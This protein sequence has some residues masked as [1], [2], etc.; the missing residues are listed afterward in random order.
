MLPQRYDRCRL[1]GSPDPEIAHVP[2]L[3]PHR[4]RPDHQPEAD[5]A[6]GGGG[7]LDDVL[8]DP[9]ARDRRGAGLPAL[10]LSGLLGLPAAQR[11]A[12]VPLRGL[13][14]RLQ[15]DLGHPVRLPQAG[16]PRLPGGG[17]DLLRRGQ[18]QGRAGAVARPRRP[19]QDRLRPGPQA[20]RGD[21]VGGQGP[22]ARRRRAGMSRSTAV[23]SAATSG[24]RTGR[25][26]AGTG[27]WRRTGAA[28]A[29]SSW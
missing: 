2:A 9:L 18:G 1:G 7:G 14:A 26:T 22:A 23:T 13:P 24:P 11:G 15:P 8:F 19:V 16:D 3:S 27:V 4:R 20:P 12:A 17:R 25:R 29:R 28:S 21:G 10:R 5:P 6:D